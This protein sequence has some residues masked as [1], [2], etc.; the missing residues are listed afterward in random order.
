MI[1]PRPQMVLLYLAAAA[2]F[3]AVHLPPDVALGFLDLRRADAVTLRAILFST[4][5]LALLVALAFRLA[6]A[7]LARLLDL[8]VALLSVAVSGA[9]ALLAYPTLLRSFGRHLARMSTG[10][11]DV[12]YGYYHR[13]LLQPWLAEI[14]GFRGDTAYLVF[15][16]ALHVLFL[17]LVWIYL[18]DRRRTG[19]S[20]PAQTLLMLSLGT[21]SFVLFGYQ[22]PGYGDVS[23]FIAFMLLVLL[24]LDELAG[25]I[26]VVVALAATEASS[27]VLVPLLLLAAPRALRWRGL[28]LV[29]LYWLIWIAA[30]RFDVVAIVATHTTLGQKSG[31]TMLRSAGWLLPLGILFAYKLWWLLL[32]PM[33]AAARA[34][35]WP[36]LAILGAA[37]LMLPLMDTSRL[38]GWGFLGLLMLT[39]ATFAARPRAPRL[40]YVV[41]ALNVLLP[42]VY[43]GTNIGC[44]V[45]PGLYVRLVPPR[46][47]PPLR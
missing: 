44:T 15:S 25:G 17:Y 10:P 39:R 41:A 31:F 26:L 33:A 46:I 12:S 18:F 30:M 16:M 13:R 19:P 1:R 21:C 35:R 24:P 36:A 2:I 27:W 9:L 14:L 47:C 20:L 43:I 38:I 45:P 4:P 40:F 42:S 28:A 22:F 5:M 29:A 11:F 23:A 32:V 37:F 34:V 3:L 7:G 6:R 8:R